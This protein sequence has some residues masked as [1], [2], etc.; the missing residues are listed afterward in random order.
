M[1]LD[2]NEIERDSIK[3]FLRYHSNG[4]SSFNVYLN[5]MGITDVFSVNEKICLEILYRNY[6]IAH[7]YSNQ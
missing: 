7:Y 1:K 2:G 6:F 4:K 3:N 5:S